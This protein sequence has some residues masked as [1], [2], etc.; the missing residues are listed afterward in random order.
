MLKYPK[1]DA[2]GKRDTQNV[3]DSPVVVQEK[4]DGA[5]ASFML[6]EFGEFH[7]FSRNNE[8]TE[9][10]NLHGFYQYC[11]EN[12]YMSALLP[13]H[14]YFGEWLVKHK[15]NYGEENHRKFYL[16]DVRVADRYYVM[17][18]P[19]VAEALGVHLA[20]FTMTGQKT[21]QE[22]IEWV[23][24]PSILNPSVKAEGV[25]V[26]NYEK[27]YM[28]KFVS[29]E[30]RET[31]PVK[32]SRNMQLSD[33]DVWVDAVV[34]KPRIEKLLNKLK[35]AGTLPQQLCIQDMGDVLKALGS[36]IVDDVFEEELEGLQR[37]ARKKISKL[38][39]QIVRD[40]LA[41]GIIIP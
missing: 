34:T 25:V 37:I 5:N 16:Y 26:K 40:I 3:F 29:D 7:C 10:D 28:V 14:T 18:T 13:G 27:Q 4:L 33:L 6:D 32:K 17:A 1:I 38:T 31:M 21:P 22:V 19:E 36:S 35:D 24:N 15:I 2:W 41:C 12:I 20:P 30:F 8:L 11:H 9:E 39:P 23:G